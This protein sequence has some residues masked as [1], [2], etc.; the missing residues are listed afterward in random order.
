M[1]NPEQIFKDYRFYFL[2]ELFIV[3]KQKTLFLIVPTLEKKE[4]KT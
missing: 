4:K 2:N 1:N 3:N